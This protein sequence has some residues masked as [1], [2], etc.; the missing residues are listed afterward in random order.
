V[1]WVVVGGSVAALLRHRGLNRYIAN[2]GALVI[3]S[4]LFGLYHFAHSPPFNTVEM[5]GLLTVVGMGT[6][7]IYFVGHSFYGALAF[8]NFMALIGIVSSLGEAGQI[9]SYQQ[10]LPPLLAMALVALIIVVGMERL[11]VRDTDK[12]VPREY[13]V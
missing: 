3:S 2:G 1:C 5:V 4:L 8:H 13:R 11:F 6:G 10:P 7:F 9:G 12:K